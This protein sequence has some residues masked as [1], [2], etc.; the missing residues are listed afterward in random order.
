MRS[1]QIYLIYNLL[2]PTSDKYIHISVSSCT[3][4]RNIFEPISP[5][6]C[7]TMQSCNTHMKQKIAYPPPMS[8]LRDAPVTTPPPPKICRVWPNQFEI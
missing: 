1:I 8:H 3:I 7:S 2:I 4:L 6:Y 5:T